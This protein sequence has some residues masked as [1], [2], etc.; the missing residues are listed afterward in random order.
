MAMSS[1]RKTRRLA[2]QFW[3]AWRTDQAPKSRAIRFE[4]LETR[5][6]MA[7][8]FY[9]GTN[10]GSA[11]NGT[12]NYL[13]NS[14][15]VSTSSQPEGHAAQDLVAFA[16][17]L[18][19]AG[20][21]FYGA[22]WC[23]ICNQ[24]KALFKDAAQYLNFIE[25]TNPDRTP[26]ATGISANVT[27]YPTWEFQ[28]GVASRQTGLL[29]LQ[30][31]ATASGISIPESSTPSIAPIGPTTVLRGSPIHVPVDAYHPHG[32]PLTITVSSSNPAAITAEVLTG[33]SSARIE[34]NFGPMVFELFD[35]EGGR[36][37]SRFKQL[38]QQGFYNSNGT[39]NMTFHRVIENFV[40]QGGDPTG[41]GTGGSS[42][43]DFDDQFDLD[44]QHNRSG[45]LSYAKSTD[46]TNDSQF[47]ITAGPARNL[48]FNHSIFGQLV[49][50]DSSRK[51]IA[52]TSVNSSN[53]PIR[54]AIINSITIFDDL[55]NG[56]I[57]LKAVGAAGT[58]STITVTVRGSEG[59]ESTT[60]FVATV[61]N[62][63][64]N[65]SPFL[66]DIAPVNA[67]AGQATQIQ[68][69]AQDKEGDSLRFTAV[70][71]DNQTVNYSV[72]VNP[73][74]GL[75]TVTPPAGFVGSFQFLAG[76][77]QT[78]NAN[79]NDQND[80]QLVTVNVGGVAPSAPTSIDLA[81]TSDT[82]ASDS[83]NTTNAGT[84]TFTIGG[85]VSGATVTLKAGNN[86]IGTAVATG[87]VTTITT[88]NLASLGAGTYSITATQTLNSQT[89]SASPSLSV[90]FDNTLPAVLASSLIPTSIPA[91]Q[92]L[93]VN[94]VH[95]EEG[96]GLVYG[97]TGAPAGMTVNPS[98][99]ILSWTPTVDQIGQRNF[100]LTLTDTAG[101]VRSSDY[102][103]NVTQTAQGR[104][105]LEL[106]DGSQALSSVSIGQTFTLRIFA[107]DLR[108]TKTG[109]FAAY[110]DLNYDPAIVELAGANPITRLNSYD[111][112]PVGGTSTPGLID[113]LGAARASTAASNLG[114]VAIAEVRFR[115][116]ASGQANFSTDAAEGTGRN[117]LLYDIDTAIPSS[118]VGFG[119]ASLAV[120]RNF[121]ANNDSF[122]FNEDSSNNTLDVLSND[123]IV[124]G[125][126]TTLTISAVGTPN[127]GGTVT[128]ASDNRTLRY[129]P[130]ANFN[131]GKRLRIRYATIR[132]PKPSQR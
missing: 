56:L 32:D 15:Q 101:N 86:T 37:A 18:T 45:V 82:G 50:G 124:S 107:E 42:L 87:T 120:G 75:V 113:D 59:A 53:K 115:A 60:T 121:V 57:R 9:V 74:T 23:P 4:P 67:T 16:K 106:T 125:T 2:G 78:P 109:V 119:T 27:T 62:D 22:D 54:D 25:V 34:T 92:T 38:A 24:Q 5:E 3:R 66:N 19:A 116:K 28:G 105:R 79:A 100:A 111:I 129:T 89:S 36:A 30:Q 40:I 14:G 77:S 99:G 41:T 90:T 72:S 108:D 10:L 88:A 49:E 122:N 7:S 63:T 52:R 20:V 46:D 61:A 97:L 17:A 55:E 13:S 103:I 39:S 123:T 65:G 51:G 114:S 71:P 128:I 69:T 33:N 96:A 81:G 91:G 70:K 130:V 117:F 29:T 110:F 1:L 132:V 8:D 44:L 80:N 35:S 102:S 21:K 104:V 11:N 98:T 58:T 127:S 48:D 85:T 94:L 83:D 95:P 26:N 73:T 84:L 47:F 12:S 118:R 93:N 31:L 68:L 43:P 6:L 112:T 76:V 126:N 64:S 131:G